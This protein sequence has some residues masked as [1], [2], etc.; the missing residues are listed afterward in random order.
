[1]VT[2]TVS[3][4][5]M[6]GR[7]M[8]IRF[9]YIS[10][11]DDGVVYLKEAADGRR[12]LLAME[13]NTAKEKNSD[14]IIHVYAAKFSDVDGRLVEDLV[15]YHLKELRCSAQCHTKKSMWINSKGD[16]M[17][18]E[19]TTVGLNI[20]AAGSTLVLMDKV[21]AAAELLKNLL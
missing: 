3:L 12:S 16:K 13:L 8:Q 18:K 14:A 6:G 10:C 21:G 4:K 17:H 7:R 1:I 20:T 9:F 19:I 2:L 5:A 15:N 11:Y